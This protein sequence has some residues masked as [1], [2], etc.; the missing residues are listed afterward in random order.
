M[1]VKIGLFFILSFCG[2]V[3]Y[4]VQEID[5]LQ[6]ICQKTLVKSVSF[7]DLQWMF[8]ERVPSENQIE[9]PTQLNFF[10]Q[11]TSGIRS[12]NYLFG[13]ISEDDENLFAQR[14]M[15]L[16][17]LLVWRNLLAQEIDHFKLIKDS[18]AIVFK[19]R[20]FR[21][22]FLQ[23]ERGLANQMD[24]FNRGRSKTALSLHNFNLAVD[25]GIYRRGRYL[26]QSNRYAKVGGLAKNLGAFWGGDF[27]GFPDVGHIQAFSNG[28]AIVRKFPELTFEYIRFKEIY[29]QNYLNAISKGQGD[30]VEDTRQLLVEISKNR[31]QK[32]CACSKAIP[33]PAG[34]TTEWFEQ[35]K[36]MSTGYVYVDQKAGWA[37]VKNNDSGYFYRL[38]IYSN[39]PKN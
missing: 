32:V 37:Y 11:D 25:V 6:L 33:I 29:E 20:G 30:L 19:P 10:I 24:F 18:L 8:R 2:F 35:F 36:G 16:D 7:E 9:I 38:G 39:R 12:K 23:G 17:P 21:L 26:R 14:N 34:L 13:A 31:L 28:A 5:S 3:V 4:G 27:V 15:T 22:K 1:W